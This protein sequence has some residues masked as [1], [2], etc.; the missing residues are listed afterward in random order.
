MPGFLTFSHSALNIHKQNVLNAY[1]RIYGCSFVV[2]I[3][4][5]LYATFI[6]VSLVAF[7]YKV[8]ICRVEATVFLF[9]IYLGEKGIFH[10]LA[11]DVFV[12]IVVV[13]SC[14]YFYFILFFPAILVCGILGRAK[15]SSVQAKAANI[16]K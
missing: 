10:L 8:I 11:H 14:L 16:L 6:Y 3:I 2:C 9:F 12:D 1:I 15:P 4:L 5:N 13:V 7:M